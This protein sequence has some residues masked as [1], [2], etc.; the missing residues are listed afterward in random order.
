M[1]PMQ[2]IPILLVLAAG[3][4]AA[5]DTTQQMAAAPS[6]SVEAVVARDVVDRM[7]V[8]SGSTFPADVGTLVCWT[9]VTGAPAG[10]D[11]ELHHVWFHGDHQVA[12][13]VLRPAGS[14]W[15]T[16]SRKTVVPE[17]TGPWRVE[18]RDAAGTVLST[19]SFTV[20]M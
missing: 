11:T 14:P 15:R 17:W 6:L 19:V 4:L 2:G 10:V 7:P 9:R 20:G 13:V 16:W 3:G 18:V 5:Q 12:D 8:D 1:K